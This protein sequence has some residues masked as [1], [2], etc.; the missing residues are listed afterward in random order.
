MRTFPTI[1]YSDLRLLQV[2]GIPVTSMILKSY[3]DGKINLHCTV[4]GATA[5]MYYTLAVNKGGY[6]IFDAEIY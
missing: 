6:L 1:S 3:N 5:T 4:T 2:S